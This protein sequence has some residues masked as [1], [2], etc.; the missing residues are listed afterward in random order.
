MPLRHLI[1]L[2]IDTRP[3]GSRRNH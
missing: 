2:I 3:L 1:A